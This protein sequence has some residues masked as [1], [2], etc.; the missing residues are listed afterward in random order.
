MP[1]TSENSTY[2]IAYGAALT[3]HIVTALAGFGM[4]GVSG[5]YAAWGQH[6][7]TPKD[8]KDVRQFFGPPN[9]IGRALWA[10]PFAGG[11]ALWLSH[12]G[13]A[14]GQ[15]WVILASVCWAVAMVVAVKVIWPAEGRIR[16]LVPRLEETSFTETGH[17]AKEELAALCRPI[18]RAAA[19]CDVVFLVALALMI[20]KPGD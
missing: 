3:V 9:R 19:V 14:L 12:G 8:L 2:E 10:V 1:L 6:L 18:V 5:L 16:A 15:A 17:P 20:L 7:A 13:G 11:I 4:L